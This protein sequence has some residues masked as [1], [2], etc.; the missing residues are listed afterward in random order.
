YATKKEVEFVRDKF[1]EVEA[2]VYDHRLDE[3]RDK[4]D[5]DSFAK[6]YLIQELSKNLD[7]CATSYNLLYKAGEGKFYAQPVWDY[8]WALGNYSQT[9]QLYNSG[10]NQNSSNSPSGVSGFFARYK[11]MGDGTKSDKFSFQAMLCDNE[12]FWSDVYDIWNKE[13]SSTTVSF[14]EKATEGNTTFLTNYVASIKA[15]LEMNDTRWQHLALNNRSGSNTPQ[16]WGSNPDQQGTSFTTVNNNLKNWITNRISALDNSTNG[17]GATRSSKTNYTVGVATNYANATATMEAVGI[18]T[19]ENSTSTIKSTTIPEYAYVTF[20]AKSDGE[21]EFKGWFTVLDPKTTASNGTGWETGYNAVSTDETFSAV[22]RSNVKI[23][24][25]Y[26]DKQSDTDGVISGQ[27]FYYSAPEVDLSGPGTAAMGETITLTAKVTKASDYYVNRFKQSNFNPEYSYN[28]YEVDKDG[29]KNLIDTVTSGDTCQTTTVLNEDSNYLVEVYCI[30]VDPEE[31]PFSIGRAKT[32]VSCDTHINTVD[33]KIYVDFADYAVND[34]KTAYIVATDSNDIEHEYKLVA[35]GGDSNIYVAENVPAS[36]AT[37]NGVNTS[38]FSLISINV[39]GQSMAIGADNQPELSSL[40]QYNTLWYRANS[41]SLSSNFTQDFYQ[42]KGN[43]TGYTNSSSYL[44]SDARE[45]G[46][47]LSTKRV[48]LSNNRSDGNINDVWEGC[49]IVYTLDKSLHMYTYGTGNPNT[50]YSTKD[51]VWFSKKMIASGKNQHGQSVWYVDI[52]F[53]VTSYYFED[54]TFGSTKKAEITYMNDFAYSDNNGKG[55]DATNDIEYVKNN[56]DTQVDSYYFFDSTRARMWPQHDWPGTPY[57]SKFKSE[58][59]VVKGET[60]SVVPTSKNSSKLSYVSDDATIASVSTDGTITANAAGKTTVTITPSGTVNGVEIAGIAETVTVT[61]VDK[62]KLKAMVA[63]AEE[64]INGRNRGEYPYAGFTTASYDAFLS[65]Y[66]TAVNTYNRVLYNQSEIDYYA[67]LLETVMGSLR[68]ETETGSDLFNLI[69]YATS[70][71]N[72]IS[73]GYGA[74]SKPTFSPYSSEVPNAVGGKAG[75]KNASITPYVIAIDNGFQVIYAAGLGFSSTASSPEFDFLNWTLNT[76]E[77][78]KNAKLTVESVSAGESTYI[79]NFDLSN[80]PL[81]ITYYAKDYDLK[82]AGDVREYHDEYVSDKYIQA[83]SVTTTLSKSSVEAAKAANSLADIQQTQVN[84][85]AMDFMPDVI[86]N[87]LEYSYPTEL[88]NTDYYDLKFEAS[89]ATLDIHLLETAREY[90]LYVN[91]QE[92]VS[93]TKHHYQEQVVVSASDYGVN[94]DKVKWYRAD[95]DGNITSDIISMESVYRMRVFEDDMYL[96]V[97]EAGAN[98][99]ID[100]TTVISPA[101]TEIIY[102]DGEDTRRIQQNFYVQD[103]LEK[104]EN[105][106]GAGNFFYYWDH[107]K[108]RAVSSDVRTDYLRAGNEISTLTTRLKTVVENNW[109]TWDAA[110]KKNKQS[111]DT[112]KA[113][114]V[115]GDEAKEFAKGMNYTYY[116][117]PEGESYTTGLLRYS[118]ANSCW[119][120]FFAV[121]SLSNMEKIG[122]YSYRVHSYLIYKDDAGDTQI[123]MSSTYA[124]A[125]AYVE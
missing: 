108:N 122:D 2:A 67:D 46:N 81:T 84:I 33:A 61:V 90:N 54:T 114:G 47:E 64:I 35:L 113:S 5:V 37:R 26:S 102:R 80:I 107:V 103:N 24:A 88:T 60:I 73:D 71:V 4:I 125:R 98:D 78:G 121:N 21:R 31:S 57:L 65:V 101:Y 39:D 116:Y 91:G 74:V 76:E 14:K 62:D 9:K 89:A 124:E 16:E 93:G 87:Y 12:S 41:S 42:V 7:A 85:L 44:S 117:K 75:V 92:V 66:N 59:Y 100:G 120:Y 96:W 118:V 13:S 68:S 23:Y 50:G 27:I 51:V 105:I 48:Y 115:I 25:L 83:Y 40:L 99:T 109:A 34:A 11:A 94:A 70:T 8:D 45:Q 29:N 58:I 18:D 22:I 106:L 43:V 32:N 69:S 49:N 97:E 95:K 79:A 123:A 36:Y 119:N 82:K 112:P 28:F 55:S 17:I 15:S 63:E 6:M 19:I 1:N 20:T 104:A 53:N 30:N 111:S 110:A 86:S 77:V 10:H 52:P 38:K 56:G 3:V 72:V